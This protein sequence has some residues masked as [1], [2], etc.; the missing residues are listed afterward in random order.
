M[1]E[2]TTGIPQRVGSVVNNTDIFDFVILQPSHYDREYNYD[3]IELISKCALQG[4]CLQDDYIPNEDA[5]IYELKSGE[6][7]QVGSDYA[8]DGIKRAI[9]GVE[10]EIDTQ[11]NDEAKDRLTRYA[12]YVNGFG[13]FILGF[14]DN[15]EKRPTAFYAADRNSLMDNNVYQKVKDFFTGNIVITESDN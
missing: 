15:M 2:Y 3:N 13:K 1:A 8:P 7:V 9:I 12:D 10:M 11:I 14:G 6:L 4:M 5:G